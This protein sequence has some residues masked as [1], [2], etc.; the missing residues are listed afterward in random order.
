VRNEETRREVRISN[1]YGADGVPARPPG[2]AQAQINSLRFL[3]LT[4]NKAT[5]RWSFNGM[6]GILRQIQVGEKE[7]EQR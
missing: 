4:K 3:F 5:G 1:A 6:R 2:I 7:R